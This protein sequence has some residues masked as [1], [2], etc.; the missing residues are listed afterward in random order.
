MFL[1]EY[2]AIARNAWLETINI[3][4]NVILHAFIIMP[5][6]MHGIIE[7]KDRN[8]EL[9][10]PKQQ[11]NGTSHTVGA[12]V[13][14]YKSSVTKQIKILDHTIEGVWHRNYYE[15]IIRDDKAYENITNYINNN[16]KKWNAD[17]FHRTGE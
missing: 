12:I 8:G 9:H 10:T 5:N 13:R 3:R 16:P 6:H 11:K 17:K 4:S 1:N 15:H 14:G 2:G 7:I